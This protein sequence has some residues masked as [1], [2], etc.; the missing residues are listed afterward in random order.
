LS[1]SWK[2]SKEIKKILNVSITVSISKAIIDMQDLHASVIKN[3]KI[4]I[5]N[6]I[7]INWFLKVSNNWL[8]PL[9]NR[10][11]KINQ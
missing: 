4:L 3:S 11:I 6:Q 5:L 9:V 7:K 8:T 10:P 2:K 1:V